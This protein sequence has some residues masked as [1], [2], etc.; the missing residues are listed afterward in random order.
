MAKYLH[1][2]TSENDFNKDYNDLD[3]IGSF[4]CS[5]GTFTYD[6][7]DE[8]EVGYVW[9][10]GD[11][12]LITQNRNPEVGPL[13]YSEGTGAYDLD[14]GTGVEITSIGDEVPGKYQEPWVS[15]T[16]Y[17]T[18][19]KFKT[20]IKG[21]LNGVDYDGEYTFIIGEEKTEIW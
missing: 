10:N 15:Y 18:P 6:R 20:Y 5:A 8:N 4:V 17:K 7:Y 13:N 14:N 19:K 3:G 21:K 1:Y 11:K 12:E 2:Y 9:K 16:E